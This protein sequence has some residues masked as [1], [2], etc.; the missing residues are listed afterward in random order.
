[1]SGFC[2]SGL[3]PAVQSL[4]AFLATNV[5]AHA[6][7]IHLPPGT[8][9]RV[10][11]IS[12][13]SAIITPFAL[14]SNAFGVID[15]ARRRFSFRLK[16]A[17]G[18][19][20][21]MK[22]LLNP[23]F[24]GDALEN[25]VVAGALAIRI[26]AEYKGL[27]RSWTRVNSGQ[28]LISPAPWGYTDTRLVATRDRLRLSGYL[29]PDWLQFDDGCEDLFVILPPTTTFKNIE[30]TKYVI[31]P[32]SNILRQIIAVLQL[33]LSSRQLYLNYDT[34]VTIQGLSSA[35]LCVI[36]YLLMTLINFI[37][38]AVAGSY[39]QVIVLPKVKSAHETKKTQSSQAHD[40]SPNPADSHHDANS[41]QNEFTLRPHLPSVL[42]QLE[43]E[44]Y[45]P[46]LEE[47]RFKSWL[48]QNYPYLNTDD[49]SFP[50]RLVM[51]SSWSSIFLI[52]A[53][54]LMLGLFTHFHA[55][56]KTRVAWFL[57]WMYGMPV[58]SLSYPVV[59]AIE[60]RWPLR[61]AA[62]RTWTVHVVLG[63]GAVIF[64]TLH[65]AILV[66]IFG[67]TAE[68][69]VVL[70]ESMCAGNWTFADS[71]WLKIGFTTFFVFVAIY[72]TI[73]AVFG[74]LSTYLDL[75]AHLLM[76]RVYS[77]L[78]RRTAVGRDLIVR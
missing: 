10:A 67:G 14:G 66:G 45:V 33:V 63:V 70:L 17:R 58:I 65:G 78:W 41:S 42:A 77:L 68:I 37:A 50:T 64:I 76:C 3:W 59:Y 39:P 38:N 46:E 25:A 5:F 75:R 71:T 26:P 56:E 7:S 18:V 61:E 40:R 31:I 32:T 62:R 54:T 6:A 44:T 28:R 52:P 24:A 23:L 4:V 36:P 22:V 69:T 1:M 60:R 30:Q 20:G 74:T 29:L 51:G 49:F 11:V 2:P 8:D 57:I 12:I 27:T 15:R 53:A 48:S 73:C 72:F 47:T 19:K 35:Y 13:I 34:S 43:E 16:K 55:A 9:A 21:K